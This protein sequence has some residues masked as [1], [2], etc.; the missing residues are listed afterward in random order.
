MTIVTS[1]KT[2]NSV[3]E[4]FEDFN[5]HFNWFERNIEIPF[6]RYI[7]NHVRDFYYG[8]MHLPGNIRKWGKFVWY[9]RDWE[10]IYT[11]QALEIKCR[12]QAKCLEK[13]S[14][15]NCKRY[16]K[17]ALECADA[18]KRLTEDKY[19]DYTTIVDK[20]KEDV[21]LAFDNEQKMIR[22]DMGI[23]KTQFSN[24]KKWWD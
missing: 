5:L 8:L 17:Q 24:I 1:K 11:L 21:K 7:W 13:G 18:L 3:I 22:Q 23:V 4:M 20:S 2:Y 6:H 12:A 9:D 14:G 10:Y 16:A 19:I 15:V